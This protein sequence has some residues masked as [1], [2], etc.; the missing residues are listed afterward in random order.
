MRAMQ[1]DLAWIKEGHKGPQSQ[2]TSAQQQQHSQQ[3]PAAMRARQGPQY[4]IQPTQGVQW[5][6]GERRTLPAATLSLQ[7]PHKGAA[8]H[9]ET[10]DKDTKHCVFQQRTLRKE[11]TAPASYHEDRAFRYMYRGK[12]ASQEALL[13]GQ[14]P[15]EAT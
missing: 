10:N 6:S 8:G 13:P 2:H 15:H 3:S 14:L 11:Y 1:D 5:W 12:S 4:T 9:R 7:S